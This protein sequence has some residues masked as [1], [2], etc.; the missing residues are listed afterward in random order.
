MKTSTTTNTINITM[1]MIDKKI[2]Y[3][4]SCV[5]RKLLERNSMFRIVRTPQGLILIDETY[6]MLG[7]GAYIEKD[8]DIILLAKKRKS[9]SRALKKDV[10]EEIYDELIEKL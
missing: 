8:K 6:K 4:T 7:R 1:T 9:L 10:K 3:R 2:I 5:S